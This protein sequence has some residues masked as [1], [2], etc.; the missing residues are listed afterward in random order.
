M[1]IQQHLL[2]GV[3]ILSQGEKGQFVRYRVQEAV[4]PMEQLCMDIKYV[5][6]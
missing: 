2:C 3:V 4:R 6:I 1:K 5:Y